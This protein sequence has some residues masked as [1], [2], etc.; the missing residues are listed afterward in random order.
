MVNSY[1]LPDELFV[2]K[3]IEAVL[4]CPVCDSYNCHRLTRYDENYI[5]VAYTWHCFDCD[6]VWK[7]EKK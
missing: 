6:Y 3:N 7:P 2:K 4:Q 1:E 5:P